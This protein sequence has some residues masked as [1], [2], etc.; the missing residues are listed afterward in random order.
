M[1][2]IEEEGAEMEYEAEDAF[3]D[4]EEDDEE[5]PDAGNDVIE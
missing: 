3:E 2:V 5:K 4:E 1:E